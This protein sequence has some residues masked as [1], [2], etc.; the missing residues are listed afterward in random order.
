M[1]VDVSTPSTSHSIRRHITIA[2]LTGLGHTSKPTG[3]FR[4][5]K[6]HTLWSALHC[7]SSSSHLTPQSR[8]FR[9]LCCYSSCR[10]HCYRLSAQSLP[11]TLFVVVPVHSSKRYL[12]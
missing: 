10:H 11:P 1:G 3:L 12:F 9:L 7:R 8:L 4:P 6:G 2:R 5:Q